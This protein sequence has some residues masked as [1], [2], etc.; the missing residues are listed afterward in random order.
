MEDIIIINPAELALKKKKF[1]LGGAKQIQVVS[2][3]DSTLTVAEYRGAKSTTAISQ[4]RHNNLLGE[5]Y[6]AKSYALYNK[7][8]PI[9]I[10]PS[11]PVQKKIELME[12]WWFTHINMI[13]SYGMNKSIVE[14]MIKVQEKYMR[15]G[16]RE[17]FSLLTSHK[18][19][20]LILSAALGDIIEGVLAHNN[21]AASNI[22]V[23]SNYFDFDKNGN[24]VGYKGKIVHTFNKD[25]SQLK[26]TSYFDKIV[27]RKN[28]ILIGDSLG[29]LKMTGQIPY[30]EIIRIAFVEKAMLSQIEEYKKHYDILLLNES[31]LDFVNKLLIELF[32]KEK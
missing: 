15:P 2:D 5:E 24:A 11:V 18:V 7:Y 28:V 22:H 27:S 12:E 30:D 17:F 4:I 3:F 9:E 32:G 13:V 26:G 31:S 6:S 16:F 19:P 14:K 1:I 8:H 20:V 21:L 25:E 10:D 23:I 29:D